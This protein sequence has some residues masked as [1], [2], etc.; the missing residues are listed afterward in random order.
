MATL[1]DKNNAHGI[2]LPFLALLN[3]KEFESTISAQ[4]VLF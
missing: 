2:F 3:K 4:F 1:F